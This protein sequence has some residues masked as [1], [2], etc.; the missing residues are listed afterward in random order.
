MTQN[1]IQGQKPSFL[2][3]ILL[4]ISSL[5]TLSSILK[6][7]N[8]L[9]FYPNPIL[10]RN[11]IIS[12]YQLQIINSSVSLFLII[13]SFYYTKRKQSYSIIMILAALLL[14]LITL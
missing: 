5:L 4:T 1:S 9:L 14:Q 10:S 3:W 6:V 2:Y 8:A 11:A 7:T 13:A 12:V